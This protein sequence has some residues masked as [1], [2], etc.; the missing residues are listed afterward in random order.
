VVVRNPLVVRTT[1]GGRPRVACAT[2]TRVN[3]VETSQRE[4]AN[5]F[6][7]LWSEL[8]AKAARKKAL[9][10]RFLEHAIQL[11]HEYDDA[12]GLEIRA[13][14]SDAPELIVTAYGDAEHVQAVL[15]LVAMKPQ[16]LEWQI[17][18]LRPAAP[19][20]AV[21]IDLEGHRFDSTK[22][23]FEP[24]TS[25]ENPKTLGLEIYFI[26]AEEMPEEAKFA[27]AILTIQ[28]VLGERS[29]VED[30]SEVRLGEDSKKNPEDLIPI[31]ELPAFVK[32]RARRRQ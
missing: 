22:I 24:L 11:L 28:S 13:D 25:E 17:L 19:D 10:E 32:W 16:K 30:I 27:G 5:A 3:R 23:V 8:P 31:S 4:R 14:G 12:L 29:F 2:K 15:D 9:D 1:K 21:E 26:E 20:T 6:W 18:A 7:E